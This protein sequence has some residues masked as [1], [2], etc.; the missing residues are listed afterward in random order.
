MLFRSVFNVGT[1]TSKTGALVDNLAFAFI[2]CSKLKRII[3]VI[4]V[5]GG[6]QDYWNS[7]KGC[8]LLEDLS[9]KVKTSISFADSPNLSNESILYMIQNSTPTDN[10]TI[11]LHA[12]AYERAMANADIVAALEA[13]PNVSLAS[14]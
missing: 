13:N 8:S 5:R 11:T 12:D 4:N 14:A 6:Y 10:M 7:F 2:G 9:I 3:G 1:G